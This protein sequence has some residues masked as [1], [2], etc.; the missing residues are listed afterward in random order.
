MASRRET[1]GVG[2]YGAL[3]EDGP[4]TW[5]TLAVLGG[6]PGAGDPVNKAPAVRPLMDARAPGAEAVERHTE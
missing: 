6:K 5:E 4:V 3:E 2:G 1:G